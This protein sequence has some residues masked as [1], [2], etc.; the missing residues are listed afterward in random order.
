MF[1]PVG[2]DRVLGPTGSETPTEMAGV[3]LSNM[4]PDPLAGAGKVT[5]HAGIC[6]PGP[7]GVRGGP[8]RSSVSSEIY[9][10]ELL[11]RVQGEPPRH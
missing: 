8:Y 1:L 11:G 5:Q 10:E 9:C 3:V 4:H 2:K 6:G 7:G